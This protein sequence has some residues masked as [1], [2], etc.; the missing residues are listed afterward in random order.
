MTEQQAAD[1]ITTQRAEIERLT[2]ER[3]A[4][5]AENNMLRDIAERYARHLHKRGDAAQRDEIQA[6]IDAAHTTLDPK[7]PTKIVLIECSS[8]GCVRTLRSE[9]GPCDE[10]G[11]NE[12]RAHDGT[13]RAPKD[14]SLYQ[15]YRDAEVAKASDKMRAALAPKENDK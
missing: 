10:C 5:K 7:E 11:D 2:A 9:A 4:L 3:D 1:A 6:A 13:P 15:E 14:P 8:C 12:W